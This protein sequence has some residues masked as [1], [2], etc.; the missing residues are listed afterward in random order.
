MNDIVV[1]DGCLIFT[2]L[3]PVCKLAVPGRTLAA[4][5]TVSVFLVIAQNFAPISFYLPFFLFL[6]NENTVNA[7]TNFLND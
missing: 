2:I 5:L 6:K 1:A 4:I 3:P 7:Y